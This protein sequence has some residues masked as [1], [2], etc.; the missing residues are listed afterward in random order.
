[1]AER[2][3]IGILLNHCVWRYEERYPAEKTDSNP[4]AM[5]LDLRNH[6]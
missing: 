4:H 1:M 3:R 2:I 5:N 6:V